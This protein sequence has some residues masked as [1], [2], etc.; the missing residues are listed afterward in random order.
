MVMRNMPKTGLKNARGEFP[1]L[2][3]SRPCG[4]GRTEQW[5]FESY[6]IG[7]SEMQAYSERMESA[8][9]VAIT[10][11]RTGKD[12][13]KTLLN[14]VL[15][16]G[17][18]PERI[19]WDDSYL[20]E[21]ADKLAFGD[22]RGEQ[23]ILDLGKT[24]HCSIS[25]RTGSGKSVLINCLMFQC[26]LH[27][28]ILLLIDYKDGMD[29]S[30]WDRK[31]EVA[32]K[33]GP[34]IELLERL[35]EI[36]RLRRRVLKDAGCANIDEYNKRHLFQR[37]P[38]IIA[39]VDEAAE[40][41]DKTGE[42]KERKDLIDRIAGGFSS[43]ARTGRAVGISVVFAQQRASADIFPG[44]VRNN[45]YCICGIADRNLAKLALGD[46]D[47]AKRIPSDAR[48][49]FID[50]NHIMFQSYYI[51]MTR[52]RL[53]KIAFLSLDDLDDNS[54]VLYT[55]ICRDVDGEG[56]TIEIV[57][58]EVDKEDIERDVEGN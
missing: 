43:I 6:G 32:S 26:A 23:I 11:M 20:P 58:W 39:F 16:P 22:A 54:T 33:D 37:M 29:Y 8:F 18:W 57:G 19:E 35:Q 15:H 17:P 28:M 5:E 53:D 55:A 4:D 1:V 47:A 41:L 44:S 38:R 27:G 51:K 52:E 7:L 2:L 25:A 48:G 50:E 12:E 14:V 46:E 42:S 13:H 9:D 30:A 3:S 24:S 31:I 21:D 34:V 10:N 56:D 49:R 36:S 45:V 40:C